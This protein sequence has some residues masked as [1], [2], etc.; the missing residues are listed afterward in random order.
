MLQR[1]IIRF[2]PLEILSLCLLVIVLG[3]NHPAVAQTWFHLSP[4][5]PAAAPLAPLFTPE[6]QYWAASIQHWAAVYQLDANLVATVMQ[7]ESCGAPAAVSRAGARGLFQVMPYHFGP[8]DNMFNPD[9]NAQRGLAYLAAGLARAN[10]EAGLALAGYNGGHSLLSQPFSAWPAET[11]R[12][13]YWGT[14]IY[15]D[16][17]Q[18]LAA[19]PRLQE[20]LH[21]G[22]ASLCAR[23]AEALHRQSA[24]P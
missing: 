21:T 5:D 4:A 20:W 1:C 3:L 6:V 18:G 24:W 12:Y 16:A 2:L 10:G 19:S 22:G 13:W 8:G 11:Q 15:A 14:G 7:I 17:R 23:A 9:T